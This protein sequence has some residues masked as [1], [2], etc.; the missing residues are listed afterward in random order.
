MPFHVEVRRSYRRAWA[1]NLD[2][3][4]LRHTIVEPWR[5]E[6]KIDLGGQEWDP[7]DCT[8]K[9]LEGPALE[10]SD[11]GHGRGWRNAER[12]ARE[13]TS[14]V[15]GSDQLVVAVVAETPDGEHR[16]TEVLAGLGVQAVDWAAVRARV[17]AAATVVGER[18][19]EA[20][21]GLAAVIVLE[22]ENPAGAWLFEAGLALGALG[23]R[24][25]VVQMG[26]QSPPEELR[27]L[28]IVQLDGERP[29]SLHALAERLRVAGR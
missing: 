25:I 10:P 5:R 22:R 28:A 7:R 1:F 9:I 17:L 29:A 13:V 27:E 15:L 4:K 21:G 18:A 11:L 3:G 2:E 26:H 19:A 20:V 24:A 8:L 23:G 16:M 12:S 6:K 14:D